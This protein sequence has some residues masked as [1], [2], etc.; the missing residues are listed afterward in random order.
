MKVKRRKTLGAAQTR[1][2]TRPLDP[3]LASPMPPDAMYKSN[4]K[5]RPWAAFLV[6][7]TFMAKLR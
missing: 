5:C 7:C 1:E 6:V 2:G 4:Q 3:A